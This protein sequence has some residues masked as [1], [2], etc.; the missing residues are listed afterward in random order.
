METRD[1]EYKTLLSESSGIYKSKGSKFLSFAYPVG[2]EDAAKEIIGNL[3]K[4]YHD[5]R[6]YCYAYLFGE[7]KDNFRTNDDGEP[8]G[9]AGRPIFGQ[10]QSKDITNVLI[11]VVRYFGG[12]LLGTGG[13]V[14]AYK[15]AARDALENG[16]IITKT[17][18]QTV[19]VDFEY[20]DMNLVMRILSDD[21]VRI[22]KQEFEV[23]CNIHF[24]VRK[25]RIKSI[26]EKLNLLKTVSC[27]PLETKKNY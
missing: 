15:S 8:S 21:S 12:T 26:T 6:H 13:L 2:D 14:T 17:I 18:D 9:T 27:K 10:I 7:S 20:E 25:S 22:L 19:S 1:D 5:A 23:R 4:E 3:K 11:V 24:K 16:T